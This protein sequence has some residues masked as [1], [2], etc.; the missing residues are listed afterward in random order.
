MTD[1]SDVELMLALKDRR[2]DVVF[3]DLA[4]IKLDTSIANLARKNAIAIGFSFADL[5]LRRIARSAALLERKGCLLVLSTGAKK[6]EDLRDLRSLASLFHVLG[7]SL[8]FAID[9]VKR[10]PD[11]L[12]ARNRN[13]GIAPGVALA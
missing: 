9:A 4:K 12:V 10:V 3:P 8:E 5:N 6:A 2:I 1:R 11:E 13:R 7:F